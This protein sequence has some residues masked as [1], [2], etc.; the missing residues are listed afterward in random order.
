MVKRSL[1]ISTCIVVQQRQHDH[2]ARVHHQ[3]PREC[4][5]P[6]A[7]LHLGYVKDSA[8]HNRLCVV[9][10]LGH[11]SIKARGLLSTG[12]SDVTTASWRVL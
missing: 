5:T 4:P 3:L 6:A 8:V 1:R 10:G 11:V 9:G 7:Q 2:R 12:V